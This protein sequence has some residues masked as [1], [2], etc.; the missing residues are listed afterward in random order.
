[1]S[2]EELVHDVYS[3]DFNV[4][5]LKH[6]EQFM[7]HRLT[8]FPVWACII[9]HYVTLGIFSFIYFGLKHGDLPKV[10]DDDP[11][12]GKAIGFSFIP[13]FN[14]YWMFIFWLRLVD[15]INFQ[16]KLRHK[17]PEISKGLAIATVI[18]MIIPY[19]SLISFLILSPIL[20]G[21]IQSA[22]N[23]LVKMR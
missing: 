16:L 15:R 8:E 10:K 7:H 3:E 23:N 18:L 19:I 5:N 2:A 20:I 12:A 14:L 22:N 13:F 9:L 1:M 6:K 17:D 21:F 11:S 4:S